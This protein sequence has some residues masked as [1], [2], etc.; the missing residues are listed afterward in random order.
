MIVSTGRPKLTWVEGIRGLIGEKGLMEEDWNN[1]S[2]WR[3][4]IILLNVH[5]KMWKHCTTGLIII[6]I[7]AQ[8][9][10]GRLHLCMGLTLHWS[11][12]TQVGNSAT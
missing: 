7:M 8:W 1:R 3:M 12:T 9:V 11:S 2:K 5:R 10:W 6:I 4:K